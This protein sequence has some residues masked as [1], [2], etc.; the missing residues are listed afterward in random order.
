MA[1]SIVARIYGDEYQQLVFWKYALRMLDDES[2][3]E[4]VCYEYGKIK[5]FDDIVIKYISPKKFRDTSI[6][7]EYIQVKFHMVDNQLFTI[8]NL[9]SPSFINATSE[10][11][12]HKL[13][14]ARK[15]LGEDF[16]KILILFIQ[17]GMLPKMTN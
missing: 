14:N 8:D 1:N 12:L 16:K 17:C 4:S 7:R 13:V 15:K 6:D 3:I 10:S 9:I 11:L 5:S 2:N